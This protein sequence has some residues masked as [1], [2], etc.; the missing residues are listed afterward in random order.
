MKL[1]SGRFL[2]GGLFRLGPLLAVMAGIG[3]STDAMSA[4]VIRFDDAPQGKVPPG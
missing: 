3:C 4:G 1:S 2:Q